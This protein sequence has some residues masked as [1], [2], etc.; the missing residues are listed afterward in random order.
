MA[1]GGTESV[2]ESVG[3]NQSVHR[4]YFELRAAVSLLTPFGHTDCELTSTVCIAETVI[5]GE[6]PRT[7][8]SGRQSSRSFCA[9]SNAIT[10]AAETAGSENAQFRAYLILAGV[11]WLTPQ[12]FP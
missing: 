9:T 11:A 8:T 6:V 10:D 7:F 2:F 4:I 12:E 1:A 5:I 3:I